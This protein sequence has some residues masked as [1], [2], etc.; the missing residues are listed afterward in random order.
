MLVHVVTTVQHF[1]LHWIK[2]ER[3]RT[4]KWYIIHS[5]FEEQWE[6]KYTLKGDTLVKSFL[7]KGPLN[8]LVPTR[9]IS[10]VYTHCSQHLKP[11]PPISLRIH[12]RSCA[13]Q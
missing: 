12:M 6:S 1:F 9:D 8:V 4:T 2:V 10:F 11:A 13:K 7:R 5:I 3:L